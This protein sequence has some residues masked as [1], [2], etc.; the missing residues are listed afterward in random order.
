MSDISVF[1]IN[2]LAIDIASEIYLRKFPTICK[3][4]LLKF[5]DDNEFNRGAFG[6]ISVARI[7]ALIPYLVK[8]Y[9]DHKAF[10]TTE[11]KNHIELYLNGEYIKI[12][13]I[14][15]LMSASGRWQQ[16]N[17]NPLLD[18]N[19]IYLE[20]NIAE[21]KQKLLKLGIPKEESNIFADLLTT[22]AFTPPTPYTLY[23][24]ILQ[25]AISIVNSTEGTKQIIKKLHLMKLLTNQL[26]AEL[27]NKLFSIIQ[28]LTIA[29]M[30][31]HNIIPECE[32]AYLSITR[33]YNRILGSLF[34][35][36]DISFTALVKKENF[37]QQANNSN[38]MALNILCLSVDELLIKYPTF[39]AMQSAVE[40]F[41]NNVNNIQHNLAEQKYNY[42][43]NLWL[44]WRKTWENLY[45]KAM[46]DVTNFIAKI[47]AA[48]SSEQDY[49]TAITQ[50]IQEIQEINNA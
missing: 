26:P 7:A 40:D 13:Q 44:A 27:T 17:T 10:F 35:E 34:H 24:F 45:N 20:Q 42:A 31:Q 6:F 38:Q 23:Y 1:S 43:S 30:R 22:N 12:L 14:V 2:A 3:N 8:L 9:L 32:T 49:L 15:A 18:D 47:K 28:G 33:S 5:T 4:G 48:S 11:T 39:I 29:K 50:K 19:S 41:V 25:D 36:F 16:P 21:C 46:H 37:S